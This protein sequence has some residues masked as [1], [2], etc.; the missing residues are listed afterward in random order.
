VDWAGERG[1][2]EREV[3]VLSCPVCRGV[4]RF[5]SILKCPF[6][7]DTV[8]QAIRS[9]STTGAI[10]GPTPPHILVGEWGY[11]RVYTGGG[12]VTSPDVDLRLLESPPEWLSVELDQ[13]LAM[14]LSVVLG[15]KRL[16]VAEASRARQFLSALQESSLSLKPIDLEVKAA[17]SPRYAPGFG[18]RTAPYG[19]AFPAGQLRVVDNPHIPR[20]VERVVSD[21]YLT[22]WQAVERLSEAGF[23]E[24]YLTRLLSA[25]VL[26]RRIG[27]KL[28][29]TEWSIT[30]MD[31]ILAR[32]LHKQVKHYK[33]INE[34]RLFTFGAHHNYAYVLLAPTPWMFELLEGWVKA[35]LVY[36]DHEYLEPR[37]VY[38]ENTGGAYYAV[39][40][41]VLRY[42]R[43]RRENAGAVVFF[44]VDRGWIPLGVWRFR[45]ITR[46]ALEK[47]FVKFQSLKEALEVVGKG[48][49][50]GI[51]KYIKAS[52][53]IPQLLSQQTIL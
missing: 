53:I 22:T 49:K 44:E 25:G 7:R 51:T 50:M 4:A 31:D 2:A 23:N 38:A 34:Y 24:Y 12:L 42:L 29:P 45:E 27:R 16:S 36:S 52:S 33:S 43:E 26:G 10:F 30:A 17:G 18:L 14:R 11:P 1:T 41:S 37:R 21:P 3:E 5:C 40:L 46:V 35:G 28:V 19:P 20:Q 6:Y 15:R 32:Q 9:I 13:L 8:K 47:P 39:R 48:L